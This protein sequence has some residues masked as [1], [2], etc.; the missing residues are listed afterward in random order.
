MKFQECEMCSEIRWL[1][2]ATREWQWV[3]EECKE[4]LDRLDKAEGQQSSE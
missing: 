4:T 2:L 1:Q 3:C